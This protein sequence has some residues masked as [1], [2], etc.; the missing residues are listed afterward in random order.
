MNKTT[1]IYGIIAAL[2]VVGAVYAYQTWVSPSNA[3]KL[4]SACITE[5][6]DWRGSVTLRK[7]D[8]YPPIC[9]T[10]KNQ[11]VTELFTCANCEHQQP[12]NQSLKGMFPEKYADIENVTRC[13][14]CGEIIRH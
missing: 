2:V 8:P 5:S 10:C 1:I 4:N 12:M 6:C 13:D 7:G 9:P 11:T 3:A 14:Q